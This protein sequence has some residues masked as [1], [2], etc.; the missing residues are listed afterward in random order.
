[1]DSLTQIVLGAAAGEVVLGK[2]IGNRA[3]VWGAIGGTIPDLDVISNLFMSDLNA[4]A[5]HRGI[6]HSL[7]FSVFGAMFFGWLIHRL[8]QSS[9]HP[10]VAM[11]TKFI[12]AAAIGFIVHLFFQILAP[13]HWLPLILM[14]PIIGFL[15]YKNFKRRYIGV[16]IDKP[17]AELRDWQWLFFW[18]LFTHPILD[19]FTMYG[20]QLF[21]PFSDYRVSWGTISVA[22]PMY[23]VPFISCLLIASRF[24]R[25][26]NRRRFWNYLGIGLSSLYLLFT[27][28]NKQH[29]NQVFKESLERQGIAYNR[30][31]TNATILNNLLWTG[32]V[33]TDNN[34]YQGQYS[35][36]DTSDIEFTAIEKHHDR[37]SSLDETTIKTLRWFSDDFFNITPIAE[38]KLQFN[39][40]R[41]GTFS[42]KGEDPDDFIFKFQLTENADGSYEMKDAQG[43]P[44]EGGEKEMMGLLIS[45]IKG[46]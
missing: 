18:S 2:K 40:L 7:A 24:D 26:D 22:D 38:N 20:T 41:F 37:L 45:R 28:F 32:T 35:I 6:S 42:G 30:L 36:F 5:F 23:T 44:P 13:G 15:L 12:A 9:A 31:I 43:G 29:I 11:F 19:C 10:W 34:Y 33:E 8:Y 3:M 25:S 17:Q 46:R 16:D 1:M 4:L 39:D 21:A 14:I 27:V